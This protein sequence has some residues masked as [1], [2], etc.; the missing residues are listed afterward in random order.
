MILTAIVGHGRA[1]EAEKDCC[2]DYAERFH[3]G[4][5][6]GPGGFLVEVDVER[7]GP[8]GAS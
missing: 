6:R 7:V 8:C 1:A 3:R 5:S 2:G 4:I